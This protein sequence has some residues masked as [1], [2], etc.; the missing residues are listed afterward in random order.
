MKQKEK[1]NRKL[2]IRNALPYQWVGIKNKEIN[3]LR[4]NRT[5]LSG[6]IKS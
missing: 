5:Y 6:E 1:K 4:K 3:I 2:E